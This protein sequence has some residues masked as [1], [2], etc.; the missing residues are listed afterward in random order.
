MK[1]KPSIWAYCITTSHAFF[2]GNIK[3]PRLTAGLSELM[4]TDDDT[5]LLAKDIHE[6]L[7]TTVDNPIISLDNISQTL[8][9]RFSGISTIVSGYSREAGACIAL[10]VTKNQKLYSVVLLGVADKIELLP[11]TS[12][13][14]NYH[15]L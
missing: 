4:G 13:I 12:K 9:T 7:L 8:L 15:L 1:Q 14:I 6:K 3:T 11:I 5:E 10:L 2:E